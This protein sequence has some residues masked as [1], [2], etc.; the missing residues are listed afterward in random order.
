M[1]EYAGM[2]DDVKEEMMFEN[3]ELAGWKD[4]MTLKAGDE[5]M[6]NREGK[7]KYIGLQREMNRGEQT[8]DCIGLRQEKW[9][10]NFSNSRN[11]RESC[12]SSRYSEFSC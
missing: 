5:W 4:F 6:M 12:S 1:F 2:D 3:L 11:S 7:R 8:G 9:W 10:R